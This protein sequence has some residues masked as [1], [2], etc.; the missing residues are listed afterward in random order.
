MD[1]LI[2]ESKNHKSG[3]DN[4]D[5]NP[6]PKN[7]EKKNWK[8]WGGMHSFTPKITGKRTQKWVT[9]QGRKDGVPW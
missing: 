9:L 2:V 1:H 4:N 3:Y 6:L 8:K 5:P 7:G